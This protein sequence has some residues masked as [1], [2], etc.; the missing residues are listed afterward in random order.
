MF[1]M[2]GLVWFPVSFVVFCGGW[3]GGGGVGGCFV[4]VVV[5]V[6]FSMVG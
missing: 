1:V 6:A 5:V 3:G 4:V 2:V